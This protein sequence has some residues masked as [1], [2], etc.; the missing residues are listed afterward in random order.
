LKKERKKPMEE[1]K[2]RKKE[3]KVFEGDLVMRGT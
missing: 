2:E 3:K 1:G